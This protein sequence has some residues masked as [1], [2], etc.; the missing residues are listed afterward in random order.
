MVELA[1]DIPTQVKRV[2]SN[3]GLLMS[4][5]RCAI[6]LESN[7]RVQRLQIKFYIL[8]LELLTLGW[9]S[10]GPGRSAKAHGSTP[11]DPGSLKVS[12]PE[13]CLR[14]AVQVRASLKPLFPVDSD[15]NRK[16]RRSGK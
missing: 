12:S 5:V 13:K 6:G 8:A 9:P 10:L 1:I 15:Q 16:I 7:T 14:G 3:P 4:A 11:I 2:S